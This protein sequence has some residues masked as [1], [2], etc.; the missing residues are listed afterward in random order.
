[1]ELANETVTAA[2]QIAVCFR[3]HCRIRKR[4]AGDGAVR[5]SEA[6]VRMSGF[7]SRSVDDET[8]QQNGKRARKRALLPG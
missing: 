4:G 7:N 6:S 3:F 2:Q 5:C 1:M 8:E